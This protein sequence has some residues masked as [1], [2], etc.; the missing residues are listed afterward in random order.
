M[1]FHASGAGIPSPWF[2]GNTN[3]VDPG[4][5]DG[6]GVKL[7]SASYAA[8]QV[9][10]EGLIY[11]DFVEGQGELPADGQEV[12]FDYTAYNESGM[13]CMVTNN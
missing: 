11:K 2:G 13:S 5:M 3:S 1:L 12:T 4:G 9:S 8:F 7:S 6:T 10:P